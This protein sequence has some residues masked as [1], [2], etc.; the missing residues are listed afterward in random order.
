MKKIICSVFTASIILLTSCNKKIQEIITEEAKPGINLNYMDT[1]I[2][3]G[4]DFFKYVNGKWIDQTQIPDDKSV[5]GSF[6]ELAKNTDYN[7]LKLVKQAAQSSKLDSNSD[8]GKAINLYKTILDTITRSN[9]G[10]KVLEK[11]L[12]AISKLNTLKDLNDLIKSEAKNGGIGILGTYISSDAKD[13]NKNVIYLYGAQKGLRDR[14]YYL[15]DDAENTK[16]RTEYVAHVSRMLQAIGQDQKTATTNAQKILTFETELAKVELTRSEL[17]DDNVTYNEY[18]VTELKKLAPAIDWDG[19]FTALGLKNID[20]VIV[21]QPKTIQNLNTLISKMPIEDIK[22]FLNWSLINS[23]AAYL[24]PELEKANW[25]FYAKTLYG[26][27]KQEAIEERAINI[28]NDNIGEALGK[29]YVEN[30]FPAEAKQKAKEMI[31]NV[32]KAYEN[33]INN[34]PWMTPA[35]RKG[36]L[37]KLNNL[38]VKIGYPDKWEDFSKLNIKSPEQGGSYYENMKAI[39]VW[40]IQKNLDDY[41]KPVDKTRWG[42]PPQMVNAYFNPSYNEIVFP[43]AILQPPFYDYKA[44]AAVNYGGIGAVIGHEISHGFD[45][46]GARYNAEGNLID[47]WTATDLNQFTTLGKALA[48]QYSAL[49][50]FNGIYVDGDFT[51]GENIGDLGGITAAYHGLKLHLANNPQENIDGFTPEQRF[52]IS[53]ATVWRTKAREEYI[54]NQVK[55]DPH[56]PQMYRA[57]V[58]LQNFD[59]WYDTFQVKPSDKLFIEPSNRVRIW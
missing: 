21:G 55:T 3:P 15:L 22:A 32:M 57:Y 1:S 35:T 47:W 13:S 44:D 27:Q 26:A 48:S 23:S 34:L 45:D 12:Q 11:D 9:L 40:H 2:K 51:L 18:T 43:A 20:K 29:L 46:S 19:Y 52:F 24:S 25:D 50:P 53:W 39:Y 42:M 59:P 58:P 30:Y 28:V 5:W 54:K 41:G 56:A 16:I 49:Q 14:D 7:V 37:E 36:A 10:I 6:N 8:E 33:R 17:R 31:D 4:D 38:T